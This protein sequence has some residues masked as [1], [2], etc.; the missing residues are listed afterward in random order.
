MPKVIKYLI[1]DLAQWVGRSEVCILTNDVMR[2]WK[3]FIMC[4]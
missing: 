1:H 4:R 3:E 2:I